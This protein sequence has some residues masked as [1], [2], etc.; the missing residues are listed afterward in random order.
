MSSSTEM[1]I[2]QNPIKLKR[3]KELKKSTKTFYHQM[4]LKLF[5]FRP[6]KKINIKCL[7]KRM[8]SKKLKL[9]LSP[10]LKDN[11]CYSNNP[12]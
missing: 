5:T 4:L 3:V 1:K 10:R 8:Y 2:M 9:L 6:T 7:E 12:N 11:S